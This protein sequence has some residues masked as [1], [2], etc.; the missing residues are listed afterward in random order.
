M[1]IMYSIMKSKLNAT[2]IS[3]QTL[4]RLSLHVLEFLG[5]ILNFLSNLNSYSVYGVQCFYLWDFG[6]TFKS[7]HQW[8]PLWAPSGHFKGIWRNTQT[9]KKQALDCV[10]IN[11][12]SMFSFYILRKTNCRC[13]AIMALGC[14]IW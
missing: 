6:G 13:I 4:L 8:R 5:H 2:E 1:N 7:R 3:L 12:M 10:W 9:H 11:S 14:F